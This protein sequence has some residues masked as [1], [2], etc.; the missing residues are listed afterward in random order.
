MLLPY[1]GITP[2]L[3]ETV[4]VQDGVRIIGDVEIGEKS[5]VWFN[6][7]IRGDVNYIRIGK[8]TNIQD[9]SS[10]HVT[11]DT[12]PLI[13]GDDVTVGHGVV[14]HGCT[15]KDRC[16]I[17]M[18]AVLLDDAEIGPDSIVGAGALVTEGTKVPSGSLVIGMPGR[19]SRPLSIEEISRILMSADNY[20]EYTKNYR[21]F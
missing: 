2:K 7:V 1:K 20:I 14:L 12:Y 21:G 19:V 16:L 15:V 4:F 3:H 6:T 5:S 8:R 9:N 10:L 13:I 17:G 11:K 18:G